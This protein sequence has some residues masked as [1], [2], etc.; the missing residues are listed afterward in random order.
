[1]SAELQLRDLDDGYRFVANC[2]C[3]YRAGIDPVAIMAANPDARYWTVGA[4]AARLRCSRCK[5]PLLR[6]GAADD[7]RLV[8]RRLALERPARKPI[9]FQGGMALP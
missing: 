5:T 7:D 6:G 2:P 4:L 9:A 8:R 3:G 1:M